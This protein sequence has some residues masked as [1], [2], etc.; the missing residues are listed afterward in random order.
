MAKS[1]KEALTQ[2][3]IMIVL[4]VNGKLRDRIDVPKDITKEDLE[5]LA[6]NNS[7]VKRFTEGKTLRKAV[8]VPKRLVNIVAN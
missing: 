8:V 1:D 4:Q 6:L 5:V 2:D 3:S 7:A